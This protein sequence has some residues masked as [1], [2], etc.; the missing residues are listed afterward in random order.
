[1]EDFYC[2]RLLIISH[3]CFSRIKNNGK[4]LTSIFEGWQVDRIAQLYFYNE[5]PDTSVCKN[6]FRIT[7]E[8]MLRK[9]KAFTGDKISVGYLNNIPAGTAYGKTSRIRKY[10]NLAIFG[11]LR[12]VLWSSGKWSSENLW[13]WLNEFKPEVVFLVG[14]AAAFP[15]TIANKISKEFSIPLF[16]YYTDDYLT[17]KFR[18]NP[19]WW[20]N[21]SWL[22]QSLKRTLP[23]VDEIFVIGEDMATEYE[24]RLKKK[25][26]VV[27]N[28]VKIE[29][30]I[31][32][33]RGSSDNTRESDSAVRFAYFGGLGL[34]R[35]KTLIRLGEAIRNVSKRIKIDASLLIY[36]TSSLSRTMTREIRRLEP[37]TRF[38][39]SVDEKEI[40]AEMMK[41]DVLVHAESFTRKIKHKTRLSIST[42]IPEYLATGKHLLAVGPADISSIKYL[43]RTGAAIVASC[44]DIIYLE[45]A[46]LRTIEAKKNDRVC[47]RNNINL[48]KKNH[49]SEETR[50]K[51]FAIVSKAVMNRGS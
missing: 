45:S 46:V 12:N 31:A 47:G 23:L 22:W 4:T 17:P 15:Y 35:W 8:S 28:S 49:S 21:F 48:A 24:N 36:S 37:Y 29:S 43:K 39:G 6:F 16:V 7:D 26:I 2:P 30:F 50:R 20:V 33:M 51:V 1:M 13:K 9:R 34:G 19:F 27:M 41:F 44:S 3:N 14:G 40:I 18:I 11:F 38:Q 32:S 42:K 10:R 25:C 5:L